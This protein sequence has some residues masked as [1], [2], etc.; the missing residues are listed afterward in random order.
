VDSVRRAGFDALNLDPF[1]VDFPEHS[2]RYASIVNYF[3]FMPGVEVV[4]IVL[5]KARRWARDFL[6]VR[7]PSFEDEA[8]LRSIGL[9]L[10]WYD[11]RDLRLHLR[12]DQFF[13][14]FQLLGLH[15]YNVVMRYPALSSDVPSFLPLTAPPDQVEYDPLLHG[16]KPHVAFVKPVFEQIDILV[17]LRPFDADEWRSVIDASNIP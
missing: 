8:Y 3:H 1:E 16:P 13:A 6:Y 12:M 2:F 14:I 11:W 9:K 17:A 10:F 5:A 4:E 7:T 15:Q